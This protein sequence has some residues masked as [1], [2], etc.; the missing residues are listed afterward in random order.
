MIIFWLAAMGAVAAYRVTFRVVVS[1]TCTGNGS[2]VNSGSCTF[3]R[4]AAAGTA[5]TSG[6]YF[7]ARGALDQISA[8]AGISALIMIL[9][10]VSFAYVC[11]VWRT[12]RVRNAKRDQEKFDAEMN[13]GVPPQQISAQQAQPLLNQSSLYA[14]AQDY[15]PSQE[16]LA[17]YHQPQDV[18]TQQPAFSQHGTML[19][20][21]YGQQ[22]VGNQYASVPALGGQNVVNTQEHVYSSYSTPAPGP[23]YQP[24]PHY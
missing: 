11:H 9:F 17:Q 23:I 15:V 8:S 10:V 16:S 18:Y 20:D 5:G 3:D 2:A 21:P 7:A 6:N 14:G 22:T 13:S 1:A 19:Y 24:P 4:R 12:T